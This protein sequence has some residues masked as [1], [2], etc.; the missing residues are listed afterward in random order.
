[1]K[2]AQPCIFAGPTNLTGG[3]TYF[4][5]TGGNSASHS[6]TRTQR[7]SNSAC[8]SGGTFAVR[9]LRALRSVLTGA[10][11][12]ET[13]ELFYCTDGVGTTW[14]STTI[15]VTFTNSSKSVNIGGTTFFIEEDLTHSITGLGTGTWLQWVHTDSGTPTAGTIRIGVEVE[16]SG[17]WQ[18]F[19]GRCNGAFSNTVTNK[20]FITGRGVT[21]TTNADAALYFPTAGTLSDFEVAAIDASTGGGTKTYDVGIQVN[22]SAT[23]CPAAQ[24]N[25]THLQVNSD[26]STTKAVSAGDFAHVEIVPTNTPTAVRISTACVFT[27]T[28]TGES[29]WMTNIVGTTASAVF[30]SF[31]ADHGSDN[32]SE[33]GLDCIARYGRLKSVK[34]YVSA[35]PTGATKSWTFTLRLNLRN[36]SSTIPSLVI[37]DAATSDTTSWGANDHVLLQRLDSVD[38]KITPANTPAASNVYVSCVVLDLSSTG[39]NESTLLE[40]LMSYYRGDGGSAANEIDRTGRGNDMVSNNTV[41]TAAALASA[42][43]ASRQFN[44]SGTRYMSLADNNDQRV[45][46]ED[47]TAFGVVS[48]DSKSTQQ[49]IV[50]K[51]GGGAGDEQYRLSYFNSTDRF[52]NCAFIATDTIKFATASTPAPPATSTTYFVEGYHDKANVTVGCGVNGATPDTTAMTAAAQTPTVAAQL[53]AAGLDGN[54]SL[55]AF[56]GRIGPWAF[57]KKLWSGSERTAIYATGAGLDYPF[58]TVTPPSGGTRTSMLSL[59][60]VG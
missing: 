21:S 32:A 15:T 18:M 48:L 23:G 57:W 43:T 24:L 28:T 12:T 53:F 50:S 25:S 4:A 39:S 54:S 59:M 19:H 10:A 1:M 8:P 7:V 26:H 35:A 14:T 11:K 46:D 13:W 60:G 58:A 22:G 3:T 45:G 52:I 29:V 40:D 16:T 5:F 44:T 49:A 37:T 42:F 2:Y 34:A 20:C 41:G 17:N 55:F 36:C 27:P 38:W 9:K 6:A 31:Q 51:E 56:D 33:N 47:W 30:M